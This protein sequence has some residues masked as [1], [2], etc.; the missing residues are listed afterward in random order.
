MNEKQMR[1]MLKMLTEQK[2]PAAKID[3][4]PAIQSRL[5]KSQPHPSRGT[6][7]NTHPNSQQSQRPQRWQL[8]PAFLLASILLI[9]ALF[10]FLPQGRA[11]A[12][13]ILHFFNRS[14]SNTLPAP[15]QATLAWVEVT[16]G[17]TATTPTPQPTLSGAVFSDTCGDYRSPRCSIEQIRA[18]VNFTIKELGNIPSGMDFVG[19]TGGPDQ[20]T[21]LY[22][23]QDHSTVIILTEKPWTGDTAR[24]LLWNDIS[25]KAVIE[26]VRIG[27]NSGEYVKGSYR[28]QAG[29]KLAT[30]NDNAGFQDLRWVDNGV[31]IAMQQIGPDNSFD[32]AG[33]VAL[34][35]SLTT[36][37]VFA[38]LTPLPT[39]TPTA[40][41]PTPEP[42]YQYILN[43]EEATQKA[44][45]SILVPTRLPEIYKI[46]GYAYDPV[47]H[48]VRIKIIY[49]DPNYP[50]GAFGMTISEELI[51]ADLNTCWLCG[52]IRGPLLTVNHASPNDSRTVGSFDVVKIGALAGQYSAGDWE[53]YQDCCGWT[54]NTDPYQSRLR[55]Q[56]KGIAFEITNYGNA[57]TITEDVLIAIAESM[58]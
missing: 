24:A 48:I 44:G 55:W 26:P 14:T 27:P 36:G 28:Y 13:E 18:K 20:V 40:I 39:V 10:L 23:T 54:W 30:W 7:M 12:Q 53:N 49:N 35:E 4:W 9:G 2:A 19:A 56:N 45:F 41:P 8:K 11:L 25:P 46:D 38:K 21:L 31:F 43:M 16:P 47:T 6:I 29:E 52:F 22:D 37:S 50:P 33:M 5:Q 58:K 51:P 3:L 15:V 57:D 32:R 1:S 34:A 42:G 17:I